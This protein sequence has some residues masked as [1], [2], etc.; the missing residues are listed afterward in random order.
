MRSAWERVRGTRG[1]IPPVIKPGLFQAM[2]VP[3]AADALRDHGYHPGFVLP[4]RSVDAILDFAHHT[5]CRL[6]DKEQGFIADVRNGRSP[7]GH[8]VAIADV[9][10]AHSCPAI[11]EV[12]RDATLVD[13]TRSYFGYTPKRV[14]KRLFWSPASTLPDETR[15][16]GGQTID[17]HYDIDAASSLY[18]FFYIT[19]AD[20]CSGAHVVVPGTH[21]SKPLS[22]LFSSCFQPDRRIAH[23]YPHARPVVI[24]GPS[25]FGFVEDPACFHKAFAPVDADRLILQLRY[26]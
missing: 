9:D 25:G 1:G 24:E 19:G 26:S 5:P 21:K 13:I 14:I 6:N 8:A 10:T 15:R 11:E 22:I 16:V 12:A 23:L 20:A 4:P 7:R 3:A 2:S 18:F 17:F